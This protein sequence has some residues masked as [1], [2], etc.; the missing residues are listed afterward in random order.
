M[1]MRKRLDNLICIMFVFQ[2]TLFG[3]C[4][5]YCTFFGMNA[6]DTKCVERLMTDRF[7]I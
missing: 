1:F 5:N 2:S 6:T 4:T 3:L 7:T